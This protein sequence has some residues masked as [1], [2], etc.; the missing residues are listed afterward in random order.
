[1]AAAAVAFGQL[2]RL[3]KLGRTGLGSTERREGGRK[4]GGRRAEAGLARPA[5]RGCALGARRAPSGLGGSA[6]AAGEESES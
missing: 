5:A 4:G 1:M 6:E 2:P 3:P